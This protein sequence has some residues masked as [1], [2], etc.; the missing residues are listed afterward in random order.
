MIIHL[1]IDSEL[2]KNYFEV[3]RIHKICMFYCK[4]FRVRYSSVLRVFVRIRIRNLYVWSPMC[5]RV[6][7]FLVQ[8]SKRLQN[9]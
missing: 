2:Q 7:I 6:C 1:R 8:I 9:C 3:S 4:I 5:R